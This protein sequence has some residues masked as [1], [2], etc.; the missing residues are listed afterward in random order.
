VIGKLRDVWGR[1][2][3]SRRQY[4]LERALYKAGGNPTGLTGVA[5]H[6]QNSRLASGAALPRIEAPKGKAPDPEVK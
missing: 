5:E 1:W 2:R 4:R 3:E 6:A